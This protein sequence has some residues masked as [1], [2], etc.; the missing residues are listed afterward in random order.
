VILE[1]DVNINQAQLNKYYFGFDSLMFDDVEYP[2][3]F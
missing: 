2:K 1:P 3:P